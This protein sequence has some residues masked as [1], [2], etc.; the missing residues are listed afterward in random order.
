MPQS[1]AQRL[2][3]AAAG[4]GLLVGCGVQ[5]HAERLTDSPATRE[6]AGPTTTAPSGTNAPAPSDELRLAVQGYSDGFLGGDPTVAYQYFSARCK[7]KV[8]LSYFTGI[9]AAA[10]TTYGN[11]LPIVSY[12]A[13]VSGDL[14]RVTYTYDVGALNQEA[15]PWVREEGLWKTDD[16]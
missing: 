15:E 9:V 4:L 11:V 2:T 1:I 3:L 6:T 16:C 13:Q 7:E 5:A 14:A 8:S 10:K 12:D